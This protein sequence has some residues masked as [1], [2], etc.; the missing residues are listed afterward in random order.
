MDSKSLENGSWAILGRAAF[1][2]ENDMPYGA[3]GYRHIGFYNGIEDAERIIAHLLE[4]G[5]LGYQR[6][7]MGLNTWAITRDGLKEF[8]RLRNPPDPAAVLRADIAALEAQIAVK[9]AA[10]AALGGESQPAVDN[11]DGED[12][13]WNRS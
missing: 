7:S 4:R 13:T 5:F 2:R 6:D 9:R 10:L 3:F 12:M 8:E 11:D 1:A